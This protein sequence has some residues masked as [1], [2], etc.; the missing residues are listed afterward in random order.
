[1]GRLDSV[2]AR[3]GDTGNSPRARGHNFHHTGIVLKGSLQS[4]KRR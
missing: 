1:M 3:I 4:H 2:M